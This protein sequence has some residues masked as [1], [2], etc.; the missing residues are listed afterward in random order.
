VPP[1]SQRR[2]YPLIYLSTC[3]TSPRLARPGVL[4]CPMVCSFQ[5][6]D[7]RCGTYTHPPIF[8]EVKA[9]ERYALHADADRGNTGPHV[10][11]E[12]ALVH[13]E[14]GGR[15][16]KAQES[17]SGAG[18]GHAVSLVSV[19]P[20]VLGRVVTHGAACR[21]SRGRRKRGGGS[22]ETQSIP[23]FMWPINKLAIGRPVTLQLDGPTGYDPP[24]GC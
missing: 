24:Y 17:R 15:V 12:T 18:R 11:V 22:R 5:P 14:I 4:R 23:G 13:A 8:I 3:Q 16:A 1:L 7:A 2:R 9:I 10:T 19:V 20:V 21:E 6:R